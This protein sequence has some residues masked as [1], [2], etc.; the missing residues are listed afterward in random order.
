MDGTFHDVSINVTGLTP[1]AGYCAEVV[2][3]N[4]AGSTPIDDGDQAFWTQLP[5]PPQYTLTVSTVGLGPEVGSGT[6]TSSPAG[7]DCGVAAT[8]CSMNVTAGTQVTLTENPAPANAFGGWLGSPCSGSSTCAVTVN[9]NTKITAA[10]NKLPANL[11]VQADGPGSG[12]VTSSPPGIPSPLD[13]TVGGT[14][15]QAEFFGLT[16]VTLTATA[17]H[18]STVSNW[19]GG[20]CSGGSST[21]VVTLNPS[22]DPNLGVTFVTV[23]FGPAAV[24]PK[25]TTVCVVPKVK[26][27]SLAS[28]KK[29]I[30]SHHCSV[31]KITRVKSTTKNRGHVVG[32]SPKPGRHLKEGSR[33]ALKVGK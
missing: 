29:A 18:G 4:P 2:A 5:A 33:V 6:V 3:S 10:F 12:T 31:G 15:C 30:K 32:Q 28:A 8:A 22:A 23:T 27:K 7:I 21:C 13:C 24:P 16:Q 14:S 1:G 25:H 9:A 20:G 26:G 19:S 11:I 17:A